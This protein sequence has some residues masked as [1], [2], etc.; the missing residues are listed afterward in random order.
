MLWPVGLISWDVGL[1]FGVGLTR[2]TLPEAIAFAVHLKDVHV[3]DQPI[4]EC[5]GQAFGSE[6]FRSF[7]EGQIAGDQCRG[8]L[9]AMRYQVE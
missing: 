5:A 3:V 4:E 6:G 2:F 8:V 1:G 7:I 9:I